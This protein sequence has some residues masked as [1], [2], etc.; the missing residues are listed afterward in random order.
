MR[1]SIDWNGPTVGT[2]D[3][4]TGV[5]ITEGD[6]LRPC[7]SSGMA[8]LG[9]L[10]PPAI[11]I[12]GGGLGLGTY[13]GCVGHPGGTPCPIE[14]DALSYGHDNPL[15]PNQPIQ[16]GQILWSVDEY[17]T[18]FPGAPVA[19]NVATDMPCGDSAADMFIKFTPMPP[20]PLPPGVVGPDHRGLIDGN[21]MP[22]CTAAY[23][24][25]GLIEPTTPNFM[26][27]NPGD[28]LDAFDYGNAGNA[29]YF[30]LDAGFIDACT[31]IPN[32]GSA[33]ANGFVG[34]DIL[35]AGGLG[36]AAVWAPAAALGLDLMGPDTDDLD[37]LAIW[38]NGDGVY[39][40]AFAPFAW[41]QGQADMV[42]FSVRRGSAVIGM[43]DS[44]LGIPIQEGD[45][46]TP[47]L[48]G[49]PPTP[50][51]MIAAEN[52]GLA[53]LRFGLFGMSN[54]SDELD[55]L[56]LTEGHI[57]DCQPNGVED[58][59]DIA[60][61]TSLD[62][63]LN[64]IPDE[65]EAP[66]LIAIPFCPCPPPG[67]CGNPYTPGGCMNSTGLGALLSASGSS[68][69]VLDDLVLTVSQLPPFQFGIIFTGGSALGGVPFGDGLRCVGGGI[70]RLGIQNSGATG[71]MNFSGV[72]GALSGT[73]CAIPAAGGTRYFQAWNR[74][75][76]G[77]CMSGFNL[78][79]AM[80]VTFY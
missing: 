67:V 25:L 72:V 12:T 76:G 18:S 19:P 54:Q 60:T 75:P 74:D 3:C 78:S 2:P 61:G 9:P 56:D 10:P 38:E 30:S 37:A 77:P 32:V 21:G 24:G 20:A 35:R 80:E 29:P 39:T 51:I 6:I 40:P 68:S 63:N 17:A 14:V 79:N 44:I 4:A 22:S 7:T 1:F 59:I 11:A 55:A 50:G 64:G 41:V 8:V 13:P 45:V 49:G 16:P 65:C 26:P 33:A 69:I 70:C 42:L 43:M 15:Q 73:S 46:L 34:G 28:N 62:T 47:P 52:L 57:Y 36:G 71:T 23:P 53:T 31:G 5:P 48:P 58:A 66:P 27:A